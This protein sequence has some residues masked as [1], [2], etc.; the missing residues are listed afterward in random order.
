MPRR[1]E[2]AYVWQYERQSNA[3]AKIDKRAV[4]FAFRLICIATDPFGGG[5]VLRFVN[6]WGSRAWESQIRTIRSTH[7]KRREVIRRK[8]QFIST[9]S[10]KEN[11]TT[12]AVRADRARHVAERFDVA[13]FGVPC[14][15]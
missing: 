12:L 10:T 11:R 7:R 14:Q 1:G 2:F 6:S 3:I 5:V 8:N 15:G 9:L 13:R 4:R